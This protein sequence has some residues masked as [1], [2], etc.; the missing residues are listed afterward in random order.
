MNASKARSAL[1]AIPTALALVVSVSMSATWTAPGSAQQLNTSGGASHAMPPAQRQVSG[2]RA[3]SA[4]AIV[5]RW[6]DAARES[7]KW[8]QDYAV[9]LFSALMRLGPENFQAAQDATSFEAMTDVVMEGSRE[10]APRTLGDIGSDLVYTPVNP[11]R[12]VDTRNIGSPVVGGS[13]RS[14]DVDNTTSFSSQGGVNAPCG[15]PFGVARA[16]AMNITATQTLGPG[17]FSAWAVGSTQPNASTVNYETGDTIANSTIVPVKNGGGNDFNIFAGTS[18]AHLIVDV[19][20]YFAAP[21]ATANDNNV[22]R[23]STS[24]GANV[25]A[26]SVFSPSCPGGFRLM[27]GGGLLDQF[28]DNALIGSRPAAQGNLNSDTAVGVNNANAWL[29]QGN[30]L[31]KPATTVFCFAICARVP[32]R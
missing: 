14:F 8:D 20:G 25:S 17:F 23:T 15:I 29:C 28:N 24:I 12:I 16:V 4:A 7:G 11:C 3:A 6:Q 19:L 30:T 32:G 18:T 21:E 2:D 26:Y 9:D 27:G 5:A 31:G 22:L 10:L 13:V 1:A